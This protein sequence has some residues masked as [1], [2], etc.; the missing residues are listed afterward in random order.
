MALSE[1]ALRARRKWIG[2]SDVPAILGVS[3]YRNIHDVYLE[4]TDQVEVRVTTSDAADWGDRLEP[5][6]CAWL[7]ERLGKKVRRGQHRR[8]EDGLLRAQLDG[9]IVETNE[10]VEVKTSG[11]L[12]PMWRAD[13]AGWGADG[14][15]VVPFGVLAQVQFAMMLA[16]ATVGHVAAFL[17]GGAGPRHYV[18]EP[19]PDLQAEIEKRARAFWTE[20]VIP[21]VP[22]IEPP[23]L[24]TVRLVRR[25]PGKVREIDEALLERYRDVSEQASLVK[26][27]HDAVKA[28][29][30]AAIGD[31]EAGVAPT[32][33]ITYFADTR[34]RRQ[35]RVRK[36]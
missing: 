13:E 17:G 29:V 19:H 3:D 10:T 14:T 21:R 2:S 28:E 36:P 33:T 9:L 31:A 22:P 27:A 30:L 6:I 1:R 12:N 32:G 4:K 24:E 23:H 11:L 20:S 18:I 7:G 34:G 8:S 15:D 16:N 26:V 5:V 25:E 35:L